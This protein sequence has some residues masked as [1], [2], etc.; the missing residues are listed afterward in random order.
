MSARHALDAKVTSHQYPDY[1]ALARAA[2][3]R[4][5]LLRGIEWVQ[6]DKPGIVEGVGLV[7]E[8][9]LDDLVLGKTIHL[10]KDTAEFLE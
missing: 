6:L 7:T 5:R 1:T 2:S 8:V 10:I 3:H 4:K 9:K